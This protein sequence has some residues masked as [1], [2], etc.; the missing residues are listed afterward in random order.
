MRWSR[1]CV[2]ACGLH[3]QVFRNQRNDRISVILATFPLEEAQHAVIGTT[4]AELMLLH[5]EEQ[6]WTL[7]PTRWNDARVHRRASRQMLVLRFVRTFLLW[8]ELCVV[9]LRL[10]DVRLD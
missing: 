4:W 5:C 2:P 8:L 6:E 3:G 9:D 7:R 10:V 1:P